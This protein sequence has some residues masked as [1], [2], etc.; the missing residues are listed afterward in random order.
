[1]SFGQ[2]C[3]A[4]CLSEPDTQ[5]RIASRDS[6]S[7]GDVT[8]LRKAKETGST[9]D[10]LISPEAQAPRNRAKRG[11]PHAGAGFS[12]F[13]KIEQE[14]TETEV[15]E[16]QNQPKLSKDGFAIEVDQQAFNL[17]FAKSA[18][19]VHTNLLKLGTDGSITRRAVVSVK[20]VGG[21]TERLAQLN[22]LSQGRESLLNQGL[23]LDLEEIDSFDGENEQSPSFFGLLSIPRAKKQL[24]DRSIMKESRFGAPNIYVEGERPISEFWTDSDN[25]YKAA[26]KWIKAMKD[27]DLQPHEES[28][29]IVRF[30]ERPI[31]IQNSSLALNNPKAAP[32]AKLLT[33]NLD[34]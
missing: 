22:I 29:R 5:G 14:A 25:K 33:L 17:T 1:M 13:I 27:F 2:L 26:R 32:G 4:E 31:I 23:S 21:F 30:Q 9:F 18:N 11:V 16:E 20:N 28:S 3:F 15:D 12:A 34:F 10:S 7:A 24:P 19:E 6:I 8:I